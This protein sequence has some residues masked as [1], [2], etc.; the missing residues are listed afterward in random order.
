MK[1]TYLGKNKPT[2]GSVYGNRKIRVQPCCLQRY[3]AK[4]LCVYNETVSE[5]YDDKGPVPW[6]S[7]SKS[8][9]RRRRHLRR[10]RRGFVREDYWSFE[11]P[12]TS[13]PLRYRSLLSDLYF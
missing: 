8:R 5:S 9:Q 1:C 7:I 11:F 3:F 4:N 6:I 12:F 2:T 10:K 13:V